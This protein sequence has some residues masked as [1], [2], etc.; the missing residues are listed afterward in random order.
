MT[1]QERRVGVRD[2]VLKGNQYSYEY[3]GQAKPPDYGRI[4]DSLSD[5]D[6]V[7]EIE[8]GRGEPEYQQ[9]L[10]EEAERREIEL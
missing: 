1:E 9:A 8:R 10:R 3:R 5:D 7:V 6:I 4:I 2:A